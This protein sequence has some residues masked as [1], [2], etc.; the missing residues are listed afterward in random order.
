[1][2][3]LIILP[4]LCYIVFTSSA[5]LLPSY[6]YYDEKRL[7]QLL[8]LCFLPFLPLIRRDDRKQ[9]SQLLASLPLLARQ[10]LPPILLLALLS[11][12]FSEGSIKYACIELA[13]A[14]LLSAGALSVAFATQRLGK[15]FEDIVI[16]GI[17]TAALLYLFVFLTTYVF[18]MG[19]TGEHGTI[20][21]RALYTYFSN[22]RFFNQF[23]SWL[24]PL[25]L[26]PL[27]IYHLHRNIRRS[28]LLITAG[29]WMM[30]FASQGR[31][32]LLGLVGGG[33]LT[34][35]FFRAQSR[36]YLTLQ[37]KLALTGIGLYL[38]LFYAIPIWVLGYDPRQLVR[39]SLDSPGRVELWKGAWSV[40]VDYPLL[41]IGPMGLSCSATNTLAAHPHSAPLQIMAEWGVPAFLLVSILLFLGIKG[42]LARATDSPPPLSS[43][44]HPLNPIL[45]LSVSS[46]LLYSLV[47]GIIVMPLSQ[48]VMMLVFGWILGR[49]INHGPRSAPRRAKSILVGY[50]VL[51][52]SGVTIL[53]GT[54]YSDAMT[55]P[56]TLSNQFAYPP[57]LW[58]QANTCDPS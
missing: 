30:L 15:R 5:H 10:L 49:E 1:M 31:G 55:F 6:S 26:L 34:W 33:A 13:I 42:W 56:E 45:F 12:L 22:P 50:L 40:I 53:F 54:L 38:I 8:L 28:I 19:P 46:S 9:F 36:A 39:A 47:T 17:E 20:T 32:V 52:L 35:F 27:F 58:L 48:L 51:A 18:Y 44:Y 57:R 41:G 24:I 21:Y 4:I 16:I 29:W 3:Y 11:T 7:L 43:R 37:V 2:A 14:L 23:Q 25:L